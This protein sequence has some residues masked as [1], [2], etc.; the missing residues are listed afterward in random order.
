MEIESALPASLWPIPGVASEIPTAAITTTPFLDLDADLNLFFNNPTPL[1]EPPIQTDDDFFSLVHASMPA[2]PPTTTFDAPVTAGPSSLPSPDHHNMTHYVVPSILPREVTAGHIAQDSQF[3]ML[4]LLPPQPAAL[5]NEP[6]LSTPHTTFPGSGQVHESAAPVLDLLLMEDIPL[7]AMAVYAPITKHTARW[8]E[9]WSRCFTTFIAFERS[10]GFDT[11]SYQLPASTK[12]PDVYKKW[13][14]LRRPTMG[15]EWD[16]LVNGDGVAYGAEWWAWWVD[17]QPN[18]RRI[19]A[20]FAMARIDAGPIIWKWLS[21]S[22]P[23]GL[24]LVLVGLIWWKLMVGDADG[25]WRKAVVD[26]T[27]ALHEMKSVPRCPDP[28]KRKR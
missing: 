2:P 4:P 19:Q 22:G 24:Y 15:T 7:E 6:S 25:N 10:R 28:K 1:P 21:K 26:V 8:G 23:T 13:Y 12:R 14:S 27:W 17:I 9:P 16:V 20:D 18:G 11:K 3:T 5:H